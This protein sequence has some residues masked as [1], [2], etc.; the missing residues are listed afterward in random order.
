MDI[1]TPINPTTRILITVA[2]MIA[3]LMQ[4][5]DTTIINVA[6]PHMEGSLGTTS[7]KITWVLTSYLVASAIFMPLTGY[8]TDRLGM[9]KYLLISIGGFILASALCGAATSITE[10]VIF[11]LL[12]GIFGAA[13]VPLS[14]AI[15]ADIYPEE[16][17]GVAMAIWGVGVMLGPILGPTLGGYLTELASWRW[18][19]YINV[20]IGIFCMLLTWQVL[21]ESVKKIRSMDWY[22]LILISVTI[23]ATQFFLDRGNQD[24]WFDSTIICISAFL[25]IISLLLFLLH[26]IGR[27]GKSLVFDLNIFSDRNFAISSILLGIFGLGLYGAM[28]TL[29]LMLEGLFNYPVITTGLVMAPRG[30]SAMA[31]MILVGYLIKKHDPRL[32]IFI[33]IIMSCCGMYI[34]TYYNLDLS[35]GW[36]I[37][38]ILLQ[39]FGLGMIFVPLSAVAF[40]TLPAVM[41]P[42]AAGLFSLLRTLGSS[43]GISIVSTLLSRNTQI[44][45]NHFGGFINPYNTAVNHYLYPLHLQASSPKGAAMLAT[46][47]ATHAQMQAYVDIYK[48]ITWSFLLMLPLVILIKKSKHNNNIN[49][50][51]E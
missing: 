16:E 15:L 38:P 26:N 25:V 30:I 11:R 44:A 24:N 46:V 2:V 19:F 14:Q 9:K 3:T 31:S 18:N 21:P 40:S 17:R 10:M 48:F 33:G 29:P 5:L 34:G 7:D 41:R 23:G 1:K 22:G 49:T 27:K 47:V 32:L 50:I 39:G 8:F 20:P 42:E 51:L 4:T 36:F 43:I 45:W 35:P 13:L 37:G 6:L 28:V 12:Q